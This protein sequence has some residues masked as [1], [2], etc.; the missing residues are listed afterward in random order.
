M[1]SKYHSWWCFCQEIEF[2]TTNFALDA[3]EIGP[4]GVKQRDKLG[5]GNNTSSWY[6]VLGYK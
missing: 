4:V 1:W 6:A 3:M 5:V 2:V